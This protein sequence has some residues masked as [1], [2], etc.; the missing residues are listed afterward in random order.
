MFLCRIAYFYEVAIK[1][2]GIHYV[3]HRRAEI[4]MNTR[5]F[6]PFSF[7]VDL[8]NASPSGKF[9]NFFFILYNKMIFCVLNCVLLNLCLFSIQNQLLKATVSIF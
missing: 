6:N 2:S 1:Y 8:P 4:E 3:K 9:F 7:E 5:F